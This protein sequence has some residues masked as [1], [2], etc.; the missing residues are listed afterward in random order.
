MTHSS[1]PT[2]AVI[3]AGIT[4][5][6]AAFRLHQRGFAVKVFEQAAHPGGSIRT[7]REAGYLI[8]GG[9]NTLQL[10]ASEVKQLIKD[11]GLEPA[12]QVAGATAKK[13]FI[14]R[15]GKFVPV[16][17][18]PGSFFSTPLFSFRTKA[19]I[20]AE[21]LSRRRERTADLN[22]AE[23]VCTH[24]TQELVDY[25][26]NPLIAGIYAGDPAM[27]SVRHAF[28]M[29][30]EA[31][32]SHG[33][34]LRGMMA[35]GKARKTRGESGPA[36]I[37][38]FKDGLQSL[39]DTLAAKLPAGSVLCGAAVETVIPGRPHRI[40]WR[41]YGQTA[42]GDFDLIVLALPATALAQLVI[43]SG[44][45]RPLAVLDE[46]I[47]PPVSSLFL[48]YRR[49]QVTHPLDG[50]G[51]LVPAVEHRSVLGILFS[52]TLFPNRAPEG[53]VGLTVFAGGS[54][55]PDL[56]RLPTD[57]LLAQIAR[58]LH[59]LVGV[60]SPPLFVRHTFWPRA[61]PQYTLGYERFLDAIGHV[62]QSAPGLFVGGNVRGGI[63][64]Q[65]CIKSGEKLA[66]QTALFAAK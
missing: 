33:S 35:A 38:S 51:G 56:A 26:L 52:S 63:S 32:R 41:Q 13:R 64:M 1:L 27:L 49:E 62:E 14:V 57:A 8:E 36:S 6:T 55:A 43:G 21:L 12:M 65:D 20:F 11:I 28:P 30:W 15:G 45:E 34:L 50:F 31:E 42:T 44:A 25:A 24:F 5:L 10:G 47:Q 19:A 54:R 40:A 66:R 53:Q 17:M 39:T 16:P 59:D 48:G 29:L 9:P 46:I 2:V 18:G 4:G 60:S 37:V 22:L 61:I 3:G 7:Y 23:L 58:D